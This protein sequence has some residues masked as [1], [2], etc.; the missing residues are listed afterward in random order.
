V[1][2]R[3][4]E[5]LVTRFFAYVNKNDTPDG[6]FPGYRDRPKKFLYDYL[7]EANEAAATNPQAIDEMRQEFL[8]TLAF[9]EQAFPHGFR[10]SSNA[11]SVPR[12][13]FEAIAVGTALALRQSPQIEID[14]QQV[15]ERMERE[16]FDRVVVSDGANV[17][18]K[19][20]GR[21]DLVKSILLT[22]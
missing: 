15:A 5:E 18:S 2:Q 21:I 6:R 13:R 17:R 1:N 9:V 14:A 10:K 22:P 20:Q 11:N 4:R 8:R 16:H 12:V 7:K 19:L 3:E